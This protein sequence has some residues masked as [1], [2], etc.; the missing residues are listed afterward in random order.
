MKSRSLLI[1]NDR[2]DS[3]LNG[4][5]RRYRLTKEQIRALGQGDKIVFDVHVVAIDANCEI[6]FTVFTSTMPDQAPGDSGQVVKLKMDGTGNR[7]S[8][9][10]I[11]KDRKWIETETLLQV[12]VELVMDIKHATSSSLVGAQVVVFATIY[13]S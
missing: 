1:K 9:V 2:Y 8:V 12:E 10:I 7:D 13:H 6:T 3:L 5:S 11:T 4:G